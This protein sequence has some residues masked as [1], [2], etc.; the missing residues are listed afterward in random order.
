VHDAAAHAAGYA[1]DN[2][3]NHNGLRKVCWEPVGVGLKPAPTML[4]ST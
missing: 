1:G 4:L 3:F 2:R